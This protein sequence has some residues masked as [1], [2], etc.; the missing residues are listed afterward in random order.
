MGIF[1]K[2]YITQ[3]QGFESNKFSNKI[4]KLQKSIYGF[5]QVS[6]SWNIHFDE[7]IQ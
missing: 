4:C 1:T 7:I 5:K 2:M 3:P 6:R